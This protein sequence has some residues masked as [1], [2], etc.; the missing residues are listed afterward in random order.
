METFPRLF[1]SLLRLVYHCF[2]RIVIFGYPPLLSPPG[3]IACFFRDGHGAGTITK[4][5]PRQRLAESRRCK[6]GGSRH[7]TRSRAQART[8]RE[9][10]ALEWWKW[11][12]PAAV[13][14]C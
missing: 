4:D 3:H 13:P 6:P 7:A 11:P 8:V 2:G 14:F 9:F 12:H 5:V 1:D 10:P